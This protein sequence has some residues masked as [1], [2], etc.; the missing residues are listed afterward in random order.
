M[1]GNIPD[2][3]YEDRAA[4]AAVKG[5]TDLT[6]I[7]MEIAHKE[8]EK[9][10][11]SAAVADDLELAKLG[12]TLL[13]D[14][15]T[16]ALNTRGK[17]AFGTPKA[18]NEGWRKGIESLQKQSM[19]A[20]RRDNLMQNIARRQRE[21]NNRVNLHVVGETQ[22]YE[23][24]TDS[25]AME[26]AVMES[27]RD[28]HNNP[29]LTESR[30]LSIDGILEKQARTK[31]HD[32]KWLVVQKFK[33]H[34]RVRTGVLAQMMQHEMYSQAEDYLIMHGNEIKPEH[35]K[36]MKEMIK[37]GDST[38][39]ALAA[40]DR[41][42]S[43]SYEVTPGKVRGLGLL[44][45]AGVK[46][47]EEPKTR[48]ELL[49]RVRKDPTVKDDDTRLKAESLA[50]DR[51]NEIEYNRKAAY[52]TR[53]DMIHQRIESEGGA[54]WMKEGDKYGIDRDDIQA[55]ER[56]AHQLAT[57]KERVMDDNSWMA[58]TDFQDRMHRPIDDK[59]SILNMDA[60]Q[61]YNTYR[62]ILDDQHYDAVVRDW[63]AGQKSIGKLGGGAGDREKFNSTIAEGDRIF[64]GFKKASFV[65][66]DGD[67]SM[68]EIK[69]SKSKTRLWTQYQ[70]TLDAKVKA[71]FNDKKENPDPMRMDE[72]INATTIEVRNWARVQV[73]GVLAPVQGIT[74]KQIANGEVDIPKKDL[75]RLF[76]LLND[77]LQ[78]DPDV[79]YN[80]ISW[81][82]FQSSRYKPIVQR[83]WGAMVRDGLSDYETTQILKE[84]F[85]K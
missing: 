73:D 85:E 54:E 38:S 4:D 67:T 78:T 74:D 56:R 75:D 39:R 2:G 63:S 25:S 69:K 55:I 80:P 57:K 81:D 11:E 79:P 60:S 62:N 6:K 77:A 27:D 9:A 72:L 20:R 71:E 3:L 42:S 23:D 43:S 35:I 7:G 82:K 40:V 19:T 48:E 51:W 70:L 29:D 22:R 12:D 14:P 45:S 47:I 66:I 61:L 31:G 64:T 84:W 28:G 32:D 10:E 65:G 18:V 37:S 46:I 24:E 13:Y 53:L 30:L 33:L 8:N 5:L 1:S 21:I 49:D 36:D 34:D 41:A 76:N 59:L 44:A 15:D 68:E 17:N 83:A 16:G 52:E 58:L 26:M 50:K